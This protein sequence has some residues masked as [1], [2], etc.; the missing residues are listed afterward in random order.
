MVTGMELPKVGPFVYESSRVV[1]IDK[2][3]GWLSVPSRIGAED[4][5][6]CV[7]RMLEKE[8]SLRLWPVHRLDAEVSGLLIYAKDA[9][10]HRVLCAGFEHHQVHK[11]YLA[12][13]VGP[14]PT[15]CKLGQA[16]RWQ[17]LLLRG[18][19]RAYVHAA[20]KEAVTLATPLVVDGSRVLWRLCPQTGRPHQLRVELSRRGC[21]ILGDS[22][23][24]ST[25]TWGQGIALRAVELDLA[26]L[27][28]REELELPARLTLLA[29][30]GDHLA[31]GRAWF[32]AAARAA[33]SKSGH[34]IQI[35][36][37]ADGI[38]SGAS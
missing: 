24:G 23:Y 28:G 34:S 26:E 4:E 38:S 8:L 36:C 12:W 15:G 14:L 18:K 3:A 25:V 9:D 11:T 10:T 37:P 30:T 16:Q 32:K 6:L 29:G 17:S 5:R 2:P 31:A 13:T 19:K 35:A 21:P 1:V 7:G 27:A 33:A 22:L 20:G